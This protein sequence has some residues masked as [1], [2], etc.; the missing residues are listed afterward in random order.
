MGDRYIHVLANLNCVDTIPLHAT[1]RAQAL[2]DQGNLAGS[3][4]LDRIGKMTSVLLSKTTYAAT[5]DPMSRD[6][7]QPVESVNQTPTLGDLPSPDFKRWRT[8]PPISFA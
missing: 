5:D 2:L 1:M 8:R 4:P 3:A 7:I 6:P